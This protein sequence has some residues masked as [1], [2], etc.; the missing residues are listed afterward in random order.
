MGFIF[1]FPLQGTL[2][3]CVLEFAPASETNT[4]SAPPKQ[5]W[6]TCEEVNI[7]LF[8]TRFGSSKIFSHEGSISLYFQTPDEAWEATNHGSELNVSANL[9]QYLIQGL[10]VLVEVVRETPYESLSLVAVER[11]LHPVPNWL[12]ATVLAVVS[13]G[14]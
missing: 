3:T 13:P 14:R 7:S 12:G 8:T 11:S 1:P 2:E 10:A 5:L 6:A 9:D 4:K